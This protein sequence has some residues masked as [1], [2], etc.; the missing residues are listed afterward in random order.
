MVPDAGDEQGIDLSPSLEGT[1]YTAS[2]FTITENV[3][4]VYLMNN[5]DMGARAGEGSTEEAKWETGTNETL[6]WIPIGINDSTKKFKG[7]FEGNKYKIKGLYENRTEDCSGIFGNSHTIKELTIENSYIKGANN[8][9]G[10]VGVLREGTLENCHNKNTT[11]ILR[12]SNC[13]IMGGIAGRAYGNIAYCSNKGNIIC[14]G[15][16]EANGTSYIGGI[17]GALQT[18]NEV[19]NCI[20]YAKVTSNSEG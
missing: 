15:K 20:N 5:L 3:T 13:S 4:K 8:T 2:D 17:V 7:I 16:S 9:G 10:I 6:N 18:T 11:V 12:Q 19:K 1:N 14:Y